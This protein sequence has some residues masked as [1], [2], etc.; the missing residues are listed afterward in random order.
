MVSKGG[1]EGTKPKNK[2]NGRGK[3]GK[4]KNASGKDK[5]VYLIEYD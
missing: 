1:H 3:E 5:Q 2:V 4:G